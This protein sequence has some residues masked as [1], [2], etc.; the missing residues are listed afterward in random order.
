MIQLLDEIVVDAGQLPALRQLLAERYLPGAQA[1]G[2][3][4]T[5]EWISPP[6][7]VPG[8]PNTLWLLWQLPD[9]ASWWS[10]R[11]QAGVDPTVAALWR[12]VDGLCRTRRRHA[13]VPADQPLPYPV[14]D[15]HAA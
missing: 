14:E 9:L 12:E 6:V 5:A 3:V 13:L 4:L 2:M 1:R 11:A 7:V 10:M 15:E 8:E